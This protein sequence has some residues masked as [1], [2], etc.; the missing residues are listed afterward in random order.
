MRDS[1]D[2][3]LTETTEEELLVVDEARERP[4]VREHRS[5]PRGG[6]TRSKDRLTDDGVEGR[7][8]IMLGADIVRG[9]SNEGEHGSM[10][11]RDRVQRT[12][13]LGHGGIEGIPSWPTSQ[14]LSSAQGPPP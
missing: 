1:V 9:E 6:G 7:V 14:A 3:L 10:G 2:D 5:A 13:R 11:S 12:N 4:E 8:I